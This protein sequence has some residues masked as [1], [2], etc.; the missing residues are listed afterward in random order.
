LAVEI[1]GGCLIFYKRM[2]GDIQAKTGHLT[3]AEFGAY[4]RLLDHYYSTEKG[5][6]QDRAHGIARAVSK[7]DRKAVDYILGEFFTLGA[8]GLYRQGKTEEM[9]ADAQP[10][11][12]AARTNGAKGGRP[13]KPKTETQEKPTG[14][15]NGNPN[16]TKDGNFSKASQS[17]SQITGI[18]THVAKDER[19]VCVENAHTQFSEEFRTAGNSRPDIDVAAVW[20]KFNDHY[21]AEKRSLARW[22][23][24]LA[25]EQAPKN[26][27]ISPVSDPDTKAGVEALALSKGLPKW[28][29]AELWTDYK[30]RVRGH[31]VAA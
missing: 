9:I 29:G 17:Q 8:D 10:K 4:D 1:A 16:E 6:P 27:A 22:K 18:H 15:L 31:G 11:I 5:I 20:A 23:T 28:D 2:I 12:A 24:W 7:D 21:P 3:L 14:F 19:S 25:N 30:A 13:R 26:A